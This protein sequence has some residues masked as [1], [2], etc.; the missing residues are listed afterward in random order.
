[1][2]LLMPSAASDGDTKITTTFGS[3]VAADLGGHVL[4]PFDLADRGHQS[5]QFGFD[6][7]DLTATF[8]VR[9]RRQ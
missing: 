4:D 5:C 7:L 9:L 2:M 3:A 6:R 8:L 1:M